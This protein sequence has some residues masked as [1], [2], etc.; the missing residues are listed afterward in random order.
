MSPRVACATEAVEQEHIKQFIR[1]VGGSVWVVGTR[2]PKTDRPGTF[3]TPG[4]PDLL[5]F[6]PVPDRVGDRM[7]KRRVFV[8]IEV[9]RTK[10]SRIRQE[11]HDFRRECQEANVEHIVGSFDAVVQWAIARGVVR[12]ENV[13]HYRRS[14]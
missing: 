14:A 5:A 7:W 12:E 11:Q 2:R 6:I 8:F 9:K 13:P 3:Q 4:I 1:S 10:G